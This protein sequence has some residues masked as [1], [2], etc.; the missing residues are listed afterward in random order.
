[1]KSSKKG[2][3]KMSE[4]VPADKSR[5]YSTLMFTGKINSVLGWVVVLGG[6][7]LISG[8][9]PPPQY[10]G[11]QGTHKQYGA[12]AKSSQINPCNCVGYAGLGGPCYDGLGGPA[13][14]GLGGPAYSG[15][16]GPC[17]DG[18]GGPCYSGLGGSG[19]NC[20]SICQ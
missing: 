1:M 17:Y 16:G 6:I 9:I 4:N 15:L 12:K 2:D 18:L 8:C 5:D 11:N 3:E 19:K 20:P 13:Y 7:I 14:D 10:T